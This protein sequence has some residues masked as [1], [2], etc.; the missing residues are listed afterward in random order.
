MC[1]CP[2]LFGKIKFC[3]SITFWS[4]S[5]VDS[6]QFSSFQSLS[7]VQLFATHGLQHARC[8]CPSSTP[9]VYPNSC[10][11]SQWGHPTISSSVF[12]F[13][14]LQ[15]FPAPG[16]F[17]M[18]QLF[19]S[20]GWSTGVPANESV[21]PMNIEDGFPLGLTGWISLQVQGTLKSLLQHHSSKASVLWL[22]AFFI[23][24]LSR[25]YMTTGKTIALTRRTFVDKVTSLRFN[26]LPRLVIIFLSRSKHLF[27]SWLQSLWRDF[28]APQ[29]KVSHCFH[30]SPSICHEVMGP[31][32]MHDLLNV[33]L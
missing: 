9:G 5:F 6:I 29:N 8:P 12:P 11:L 13:S 27:I 7:H 23:V 16:S 31:D 18:S 3:T 2:R 14:C 10:P 26:M 17:Q 4:Q 33:E 22:S 21:L 25:P 30:F 24:Q 32:A 19:D 20:D 28:G 1:P 15:S